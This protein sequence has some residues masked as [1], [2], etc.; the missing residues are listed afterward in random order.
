MKKKANLLYTL[1]AAVFA[2]S[3]PFFGILMDDN[4]YKWTYILGSH[5]IGLIIFLIIHKWYFAN[6]IG[7]NDSTLS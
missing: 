1:L 5:I 2:Y 3:V 6:L 4:W 7:S